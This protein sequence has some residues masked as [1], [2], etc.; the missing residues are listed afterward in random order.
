MLAAC[1]LASLSALIL[2]YVGGLAIAQLSARQ[3][4]SQEPA[5]P[6]PARGSD[7]WAE[8]DAEAAMTRRGGPKRVASAALTDRWSVGL[9]RPPPSPRGAR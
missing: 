2:D 4:M 5:P 7:F 6:M 1:R 8:H 9:L 3:G